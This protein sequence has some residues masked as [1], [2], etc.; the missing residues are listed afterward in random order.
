MG[1]S[2][3]FRPSFRAK[4]FDI[5]GA[6]TPGPPSSAC[7]LPFPTAAAGV[8]GACGLGTDVAEVTAGG[9]M[10]C[11]MAAVACGCMGTTIGAGTMTGAGT[12]MG[13]RLMSADMAVST[14]ADACACGTGALCMLLVCDPRGMELLGGNPLSGLDTTSS[15]VGTHVCEGVRSSGRLWAKKH[16]GRLHLFPSLHSWLRYLDGCSQHSKTPCAYGH[17]SPRM[18]KPCL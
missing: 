5:R 18:Q 11:T 13:S 17:A 10:G 9:D 16:T 2:F 12:T 3:G 7:W 6:V 15:A 4:A 14:G 1:L 8:F